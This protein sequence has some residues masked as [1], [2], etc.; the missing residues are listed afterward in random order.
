MN[1]VSLVLPH[2][3]TFPARGSSSSSATS[4]RNMGPRGSNHTQ[5]PRVGRVTIPGDTVSSFVNPG[6]PGHYNP[7]HRCRTRPQ[8]P[9]LR[10]RPPSARRSRS[11]AGS[12]PAAR[13][14]PISGCCRVKRRPSAAARALTRAPGAALGRKYAPVPNK[15]VRASGNRAGARDRRTL[16]PPPVVQLQLFEAADAAAEVAEAEVDVNDPCVLPRQP[17]RA[18]A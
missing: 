4:A 10:L 15:S 5:T 18:Q 1:T 16:D 14:V 13:S 3:T 17:P 7:P 11:R 12:S 9:V 8:S 2:L 6:E